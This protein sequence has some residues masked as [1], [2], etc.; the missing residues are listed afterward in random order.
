MHH[1]HDSYGLQVT[2]QTDQKPLLAIAKNPLRD[3]PKHLQIMLLQLQRYDIDLTCHR[4]AEM[5]LADTPSRANIQS[6]QTPKQ[7][8]LGKELEVVCL[9]DDTELTD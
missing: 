6:T 3:A 9:L 1:R 4:G 2:I 7:L 8:G 5:Y